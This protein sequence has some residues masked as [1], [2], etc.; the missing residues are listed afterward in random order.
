MQKTKLGISVGLLG[1]AI[2]FMGVINIIPMIL[3]AGYVLW[4]EDNEWLKKL[5][6]KAVI[7]FVAAAILLAFVGIL[8]DVVSF[9]NSLVGSFVSNF[10]IN[11]PLNLDALL[12]D[13]IC[14]IRDG[15]LLILGISALHQG[16]I[17]VGSVDKLVDK[18]M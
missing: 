1:A 8:D 5:A 18:N 10:T 3:L 17:S 4:A 7:V 12:K 15:L 9:C 16:S 6:V 11:I 14:V 2:C 13:I